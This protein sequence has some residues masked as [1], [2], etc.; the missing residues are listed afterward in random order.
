MLPV[1]ISL[2]SLTKV[3]QNSSAQQT[4]AVKSDSFLEIKTSLE[5]NKWREG[6]R[7]R[8]RNVLFNSFLAL[9]LILHETWLHKV[10]LKKKNSSFVIELI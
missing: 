6:D 3:T 5:K 7:E 2:L 8:Q 4:Q 1:S 10:V 9:D